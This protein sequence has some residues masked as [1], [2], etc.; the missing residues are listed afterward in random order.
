MNPFFMWGALATSALVAALFFLKFWSTSRDRLFF[1]FFLAFLMFSFNWIGLALFQSVPESRH[2]VMLLR[3]LAFSLILI[4]IFDKNRRARLH[5][6]K[7]VPVD[8]SSGHT[9]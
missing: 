3:L 4:G 1:F 8:S 9:A 5:E 2:K 7:G 6:K